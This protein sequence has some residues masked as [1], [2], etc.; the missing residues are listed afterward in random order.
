MTEPIFSWT[1][2]NMSAGP[3]PNGGVYESRCNQLLVSGACQGDNTMWHV[4]YLQGS[5]EIAFRTWTHT[6][7][8]TYTEVAGK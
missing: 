8:Q 4:I 7:T 5:R 2:N 3:V 6:H 1:C